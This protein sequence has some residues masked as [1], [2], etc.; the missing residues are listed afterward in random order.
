VDNLLDMGD[1]SEYIDV[2]NWKEYLSQNTDECFIMKIRSNT[3]RGKP[4]GSD[5]FIAAGE[6]VL[7]KKILSLPR[8]RPKIVKK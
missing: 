2:S 7:G 1:I 8:G 4:L 5:I 6:N 3:L